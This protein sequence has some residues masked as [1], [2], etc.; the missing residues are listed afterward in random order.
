MWFAPVLLPPIA[1]LLAR[2]SPPTGGEP[3]VIDDTL[4]VEGWTVK[5]FLPQERKAIFGGAIRARYGPTVLEAE[6]LILDLENRRGEARGQVRVVDP[7][8]ELRS[9]NFFFDWA[10]KT[11]RAESVSIRVKELE[12]SVDRVR[13]RPGE[14]V[15][16]GLRFALCGKNPAGLG[17]FSQR[18]TIQPGRRL[19]AS[20]PRFVLL[21]LDLRGSPD[22]TLSLDRRAQG[23]RIPRPGVRGGATIGLAWDTGLMLD[24]RTAAFALVDTFPRSFPRLEATVVASSVDPDEAPGLLLPLNDLDIRFNDSFMDDLTVPSAEIE[25]QRLGARRRS[26]ALRTAW[27]QATNGRIEDSDQVSKRWEAIAEYGPVFGL[28]GYAQLRI[29]DIRGRADEPFRVRAFALLGAELLRIPLGPR[30]DFK[31]RADA[32]GSLREGGGYGWIRG[33]ASLLSR[34]SRSWE[35]GLSW[36]EAVEAGVPAYPFDAL[37]FRRTLN[38]R[39]AFEE[40]PWKVSMLS[41]WDPLRGVFVDHQYRLGL[42]SG[43]LEPYVIFR[44]ASQDTRIGA[45]LRLDAVLDRLQRRN[46]RRKASA[47]SD[48]PPGHLRAG[49]SRQPDEESR[50]R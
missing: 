23:L 38:L 44:Q 33:Q 46:Q 36:V 1:F 22:I 15:A 34:P 8:G 4:V 10:E 32:E 30:V 35:V 48:L 7:E 37:G 14:W 40:G 26:L 45:S 49:A 41:K 2:P 6:E 16:E 25:R 50:C 12:F 39:A 21:G 17:V 31:L 19:I 43:C 18:V 20:D 11:G 24:D 47:G 3:V 5:R 9:E 13:V 29:H 42:V 27:N 28:D